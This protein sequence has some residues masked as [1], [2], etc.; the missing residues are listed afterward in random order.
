MKFY[1]F[2]ERL[3]NRSTID[4]S[5]ALVGMLLNKD[6]CGVL[7]KDKSG[8]FALTMSADK[9]GY[10]ILKRFSVSSSMTLELQ[11]QCIMPEEHLQCFKELLH[12]KM[13]FFT[14]R[15]DIKSEGPCAYLNWNGEWKH[16]F[17]NVDVDSL[18]MSL[19]DGEKTQDDEDEDDW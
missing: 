8:S 3:I 9:G 12:R 14:R 16:V 19:I 5:N 11:D 18:G 6:T 7:F 4:E 15:T 10:Y 1:E 17:P 2:L 13:D